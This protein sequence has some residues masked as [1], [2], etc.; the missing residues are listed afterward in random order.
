MTMKKLFLILTLTC[1]GSGF[2]ANA[3]PQ[4]P[5]WGFILHA[6]HQDVYGNMSITSRDP[7]VGIQGNWVSDVSGA[8]GN[9]KFFGPTYTN[10]SADYTVTQGRT[11]AVWDIYETT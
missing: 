8:A 11:P 2:T 1:L 6:F 4:P 3:C 5:G 10:A 7:G 9:V